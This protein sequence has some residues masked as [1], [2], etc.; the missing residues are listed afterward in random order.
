LPCSFCL[1]HCFFSATLNLQQFRIQVVSLCGIGIKRNGALIFLFRASPIPIHESGYVS[2]EFTVIRVSNSTQ[3][4]FEAVRLET[5]LP[6]R[7]SSRLDS[8][9]TSDTASDGKS[10]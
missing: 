7:V 4:T 3:L 6:Y 8:A 9:T 2:A 10:A 5:R 1:A